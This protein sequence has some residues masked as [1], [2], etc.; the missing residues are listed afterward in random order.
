M[1]GNEGSIRRVLLIVLF[2]ALMVA[3]SGHTETLV[4]GAITANTTWTLAGSPYRVTGNVTVNQG[5]TL[6]ID[7]G[8]RVEFNQ[9]TVM[10][11]NGE[12]RAIGT[13][14]QSIRFTG[15]TEGDTGW[16]AGI[17]LI[18][19]GSA[20]L[21][22]CTI[23]YAGYSY[24]DAGLYKSGSGALTLASTTLDHSDGAGLYLDGHTG[25]VTS[26]GNLFSNNARGVQVAINTSF[27]HDD[28]STFTGNTYDVYLNGGTMSGV[29]SWY[30]NPAYSMYLSENMTVA[31][32]AAL[33]V[34]PGTVVKAAQYQILTIQG[35][36]EARGEAAKPI[37]FTDRRDD[38]SGGDANG[39]GNQTAPSPGWWAGISVTGS[40]SADLEYC[41]LAYAG[42]SY[43]NAGV[44]KSGSGTL[45]LES[46]TQDHSSGAGLYLEGHTGV[47]T[48]S[49]NLFSN[50]ARGVQVAINTSFQ[51]DDTSTFTG[52]GSDVYL[53]GGTISGEVSWYLNPA[54]SMY[55]SGSITESLAGVLRVLPGTVV[56]A[57][58]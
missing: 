49:G 57:A 55:L 51:H 34:L 23:A 20:A 47:L 40:G 19:S 6:T 27:Q 4:S 50:N 12:L 29:V 30:L 22:H 2:L 14:A 54:Y 15:A 9:Y 33:R 24:N 7:A 56:K 43:K 58:P 31:A 21:E 46:T 52:N 1:T 48:S 8:V 41:T 32:G 5:V 25:A 18:G 16:W 13:S 10:N 17:R 38:A 42:Y 53:N 26:S 39:D 45:T 11:V 3:P 35:S 28:T 37:V 36:L 44:Y